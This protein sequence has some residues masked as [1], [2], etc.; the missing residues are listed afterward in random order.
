MFDDSCLGCLENNVVLF[1][2]FLGVYLPLLL[3]AVMHME[4]EFFFEAEPL[5]E[6]S[7]RVYRFMFS[8]RVN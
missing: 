1:L 8:R 4:G 3:F 2:F 7:L 5:V 6:S